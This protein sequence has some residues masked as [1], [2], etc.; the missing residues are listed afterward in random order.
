MIIRVSSIFIHVLGLGQ[1]SNPLIKELDPWD[2]IALGI[3]IVPNRKTARIIL[4]C[5]HKNLLLDRDLRELGPARG[6]SQPTRS[7]SIQSFHP[8][9]RLPNHILILP[10]KGFITILP[11]PLACYMYCLFQLA[12]FNYPSNTK[13]KHSYPRN[14]PWRPIGL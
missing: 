2:R 12:L 9:T 13:V 5:F 14:R 1:Q 4:T 7:I 11:L 6:H 3:L 8:N 10:N